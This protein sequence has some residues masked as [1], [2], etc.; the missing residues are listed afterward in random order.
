VKFQSGDKVQMAS[1]T[2]V[3]NR[4]ARSYTGVIIGP[5]R[6]PNH[7]RIRR[8]GLKTIELWHENA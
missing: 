7:V 2:Y 8:D 6:L 5:S 1:D 4:D 3:L